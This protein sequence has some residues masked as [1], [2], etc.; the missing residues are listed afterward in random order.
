M[1]NTL[2]RFFNRSSA[3]ITSATLAWAF[4]APSAQGQS[5]WN[6]VPG[7][8]ANTNWSTAGNWTPSGVPGPTTV[9]AFNLLS[10]VANDTTINNV[11]DSGFGGTISGLSYGNSNNFENTLIANGVT[12]NVTGIDG[13]TNGSGYLNQ[14]N[15]ISYGTTISG[16]GA[17][18]NINNPNATIFVGWGNT[19]SSGQINGA[20]VLNLSNLD[21]FTA[22][23]TNL[24]V[25]QTTGTTSNRACAGILYLARTNYITAMMTGSNYNSAIVIGD[26]NN[27]PATN[28]AIYLGQSNVISAGSIG[29]GLRKQGTSSDVNTS[30]IQ[31][32]PVFTNNN[33]VVY[34]RA[35]DGV[36]A[37]ENWVIGDSIYG[38]ATARGSGYFDFS[39][40]TVNALVTTIVV[41]RTPLGGTGGWTGHGRLTLTGGTISVMNL[42]NA[43]LANPTNTTQVA[44]GVVN[45]N[46]TGL[47]AVYGNLIMGALNGN[48]G[49]VTG[50]LNITN[51]TVEANMITAGGGTSAINLSGGTLVVTN[52]AGLLGSPLTSLNMTNGTLAMSVPVSGITN[53]EVGTLNMNGTA[54]T[55]TINIISLPVGATAPAQYPL[56]GYTNAVGTLNFN[57][58]T[59]PPSYQGYIYNNT[60][61]SRIDLVLTNSAGKPD[62]WG[63]G[64]NNI[65]DTTSLNWT[66][67]G[68]AVK[69][70]EN[71]S[72]TFNDFAHTSAITFTTTHTPYGFTVTNNVLNYTFSG[73]GNISGLTSLIKNGTASL[74]LAETGGDNFSGGISANG[75]TLVLDDSSSSISGGMTIASGATVQIGNNDAN[76]AVPTG[77]FDDEGTLAFKRTDNVTLSSA[78]SG[79]GVLAQEGGGIL[80]LNPNNTYTGSTIVGNGTL[81]LVNSISISNSVGV[82]VS[83][84]T[85]DVSALGGKPAIF[86]PLTITN[87]AFNVEFSTNLQAPISVSGS[88]TADGIIAVSNKINILSLPSVIASYPATFTVIQSGGTIS[89]ENGNFNFILGSLPTASP[90]YAGKLVESGDRTSVLITLTSGPVGTRPSVFW[91][92]TNSVSI[93]TNWSD[94]L[95]W[96]LPGAPVSSDNVIFNNIASMG[97]SA[98][99]APGAGI[100][101]LISGNINNVVD[102]S[103]T[104]SSLAYT[105]ATANPTSPLSPPTCENTLIASGATLNVTGPGGLTVGGPNLDD[106]ADT[107]GSSAIIAGAGGTLN[108]T[109]TNSIIYVGWGDAAGSLTLPAVLDM[110]ALDT[111]TADISQMEIG[112]GGPIGTANSGIVYLALTNI[113]RA[114]A[115]GNGTSAAIVVGYQ[116]NN[117]GEASF[118]YL[119]QTNAIYA[120]SIACGLIKQGNASGIQFNPALVG[121]NPAA[122]FRANDGVSPVSSWILG[123]GNTEGGTDNQW[124]YCDFSG[125]T[126][127][128]MVDMMVLASPAPG[129]TKGYTATGSFTFTAGNISV[130]I[131]TNAILTL[132]TNAQTATGS[133]NVNGTATLSVTTNLILAVANGFNGNASGSLNITNGTA[134]ANTITAGGGNSAINLNAGTLIVTNTVGTPG[135]PLTSLN[136]SGGTLQLNVNANGSE[137]NIV[138]TTVNVNG[139]T[140]IN[141]ASLSN[142]NGTTQTPLISYTGTD[143]TTSNFTIGTIPAG[144][145]NPSLVDDTAKQTIDLLITAS[146]ILVPT[147]SPHITSFTPNF[148][149]GNVVISGTNGQAGATYYTLSSTNVGLPLH[150]WT[151]VATNVLGSANFS[152][153]NNL[154]LLRPQQYFIL[155]STNN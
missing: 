83:N 63:G 145:S 84:A 153:T 67:N 152:V 50:T 151:P 94:R 24:M 126:V 69:Y 75:G 14:T 10:S 149:P 54:N 12:L 36:S 32:N 38:Q 88:L 123:S 122:Y 17:A 111:F 119:G 44:T 128:A 22:T 108:V 105:N 107:Y 90:A 27:N 8:S 45:V 73:S 112:Q 74:T 96:Q 146:S 23:I 80:T 91:V 49:S 29:C 53:V 41:G 3:I 118:L 155:S 62:V 77:S 130:G 117:N 147:N 21:T 9:V 138:A 104:V 1:K 109:N 144:C 121:N 137:T 13:L 40:G 15:L 51:G 101:A 134:Q 11:V 115:T 79:G 30:G 5:I 154:I 93:T 46:G 31:F 76:G 39:G 68:V 113:I 37:M 28:S 98:L 48:T 7:A 150:E 34:L 78:I 97:V 61:D 25:G 55:N 143:P 35:S 114:V 148:G 86:G 102:T 116:T 100:S 57:L 6:A 140:T 129:A 132:K 81:A 64:V 131:I 133:V 42:T 72:V 18:L 103:F 125:G 47:L 59:L 136:L 20:A 95:N 124:G 89:L 65:W 82:L 26:N 16:V 2:R 141:I 52:T 142:P 99:S 56:I 66:N 92:G 71:D 58:G 60:A 127:D 120:N 110:S 139:T 85:L 70:A 4:I 135:V 43:V 19:N 33:P 87:A 106:G